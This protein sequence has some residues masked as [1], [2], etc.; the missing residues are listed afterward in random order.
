MMKQVQASGL[1]DLADLPPEAARGLYKQILAAA[2]MPPA[3][4]A[5]ANAQVPAQGRAPAVPLRIYTPRSTGP[6]ALVVYYHGGGY[7]LGD[8]DGYDGV[9]R[10]LCHDSDAVVVS[11]EYR[12]APEHAMPAGVDDAWAALRWA[13][14]QAT[15]LGAD[16]T[17]LG[18]AGDSAGAVF[19]TVVCL[20]A[21]D[22][23]GPQVRF[24]ALL[25]PPAAGGHG[26]H[27][28]RRE[29]AAGPTLTQRSMDCFNRTT[30]GPSGQA[31]DFRYAP[32]LAANLGG[33]PPAWLAAAG[34]D[35]L[36]DEVLAY[37][38][39]LLTAGTPVAMVEYHGLA[40]GFISMAG[41]IPTA[42]LAQQQ[43]AQALGTG[44][45]A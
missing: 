32:L 29:H 37:G 3:D 15:A 23:Q 44:L 25:Y 1:P 18:V 6:H 30:F 14:E 24:Q 9:C 10:Q 35:P 42:R 20:L 43:F 38:N 39:A 4:V 7:M 41:A 45:A 16:P 34:H 26:D 12:L 2:N 11:V 22:A 21:R 19:A 28:S 40:H 13:A 33:L 17:R 36:R 31:E 5:V 8:L 27:A